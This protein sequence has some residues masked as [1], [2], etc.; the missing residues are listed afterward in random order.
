ME[1]LLHFS[2][3]KK[4]SQIAGSC[5]SW[6]LATLVTFIQAF[7]IL[8]FWF[9]TTYSLKKKKKRGN[10][11]LNKSL[12]FFFYL[13]SLFVDLQTPC[14]FPQVCPTFTAKKCWRIMVQHHRSGRDC[15]A[16]PSVNTRYKHSVQHSG[17][18]LKIEIFHVLSLC[19][20]ICHSVI[21][22]CSISPNFRVHHQL[23]IRQPNS[24]DKKNPVFSQV[25][26]H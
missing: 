20:G 18:Q 19:F 21:N 14:H 16:K 8:R 4:G 13:P 12:A 25:Y 15:G 11:I 26:P 23:W 9:S 22:F 3:T 1:R 24:I 17:L 6:G 10:D 2:F 5:T 7:F